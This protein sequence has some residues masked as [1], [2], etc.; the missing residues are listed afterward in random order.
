MG[1]RVSHTTEN[2]LGMLESRDSDSAAVII[3]ELLP[4]QS[5][6]G[7]EQPTETISTLALTFEP[8]STS[9]GIES[10]SIAVGVRTR[11]ALSFTEQVSPRSV[12]HG[13]HAVAVP[14]AYQ[15]NTSPS[16]LKVSFTDDGCYVVSPHTTGEAPSRA[17]GTGS[18]LRRLA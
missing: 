2:G 6:G 12:F 5:W 7:R 8:G 18:R 13:H 10:V 3:P 9:L 16:E 1:H 14:A 11:G 4:P 15:E 17:S